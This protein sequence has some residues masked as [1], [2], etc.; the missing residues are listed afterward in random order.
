MARSL[1]SA[2]LAL[3][4]LSAGAA[5][6]TLWDGRGWGEA[7][8]ALRV[9]FAPD[10]TRLTEDGWLITSRDYGL[11]FETFSVAVEAVE[12]SIADVDEAGE[13]SFDP[14]TPPPGY[15]LCHNG[16]CHSDA[17]DLVDYADIEAELAGGVAPG[18]T[19]VVLTATDEVTVSTGGS[20]VEVQGCDGPCLL[21]R[22]VVERVRV[23]VAAIE[24]SGQLYELRTGDQVR[25][26][27]EGAPFAG[28]VELDV[29]VDAET[30][31]PLDGS[32]PPGVA[33]DLVV[34]VTPGLFD[35]IGLAFFVEEG[36]LDLNADPGFVAQSLTDNLAESALLVDV[37]REE[38]EVSGPVLFPQGGNNTGSSGG[39]TP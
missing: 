27:A 37:T 15:S 3:L 12:L 38:V 31:I 29:D 39:D 28:R 23:R 26:P 4:A 32:E 6:C 7:D 19:S 13:L 1:A 14:A 30:A 2:G 35:G 17:G 5:S 16:H 20:D 21:P 8:A 36:A 33:L 18:A 11:A 34:D 24:L 25:L 9:R 10:D 22:G